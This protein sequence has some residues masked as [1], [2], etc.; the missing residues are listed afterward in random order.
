MFSTDR[1]GLHVAVPDL[2][3]VYKLFWA[4]VTS[5]CP[6]HLKVGRE[7]VEGRDPYRLTIRKSVLYKAFRLLCDNAD[8][9]F[10]RVWP[11]HE[12]SVF[13]KSSKTT[14]KCVLAREWALCFPYCRVGLTLFITS[15]S[16]SCRPEY[17]L[18]PYWLY[19]R[20]NVLLTRTTRV[21]SL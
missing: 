17:V 4:S 1:R 21:K 16:R 8:G 12:S 13:K 10:V 2:W 14:Y 20:K 18:S 19:W 9:F 5:T 15:R 6:M 7:L 11:H 3:R